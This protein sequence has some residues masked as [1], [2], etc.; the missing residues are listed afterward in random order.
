MSGI[1]VGIGCRNRFNPFYDRRKCTFL[2]ERFIHADRITS[3]TLLVSTILMRIFALLIVG[4]I[5]NHKFHKN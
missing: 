2:H 4:V 1:D 5:L 3:Q